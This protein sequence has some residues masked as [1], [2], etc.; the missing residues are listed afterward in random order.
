[1]LYWIQIMTARWRINKQSS[2]VCVLVRAPH[3]HFTLLLF[4]L[5]GFLLFLPALSFLL[6]IKVVDKVAS[7]HTLHKIAVLQLRRRNTRERL[8]KWQKRQSSETAKWRARPQRQCH[9]KTELLRSLWTVRI[10]SNCCAAAS[11]HYKII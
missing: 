5:S 2:G 10:S 7:W 1:M 11:E 3:T 4:Q 8:S 9:S 6:L